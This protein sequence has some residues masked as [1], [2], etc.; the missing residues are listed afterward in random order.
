MSSLIIPFSEV[1]LKVSCG[2][3]GFQV[4]GGQKIRPGTGMGREI[5][6]ILDFVIDTGHQPNYTLFIWGR[7]Y[8][9]HPQYFLSV[10]RVKF[11][12]G[13]GLENFFKA[14]EVNRLN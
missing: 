3:R 8:L 11:S 9:N 12:I 1:F 5:P 7:L 14:G 6:I 4:G 13:V 2:T 10:G